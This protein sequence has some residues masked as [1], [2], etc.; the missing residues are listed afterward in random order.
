MLA[1]L[2]VV[3]ILQYLQILNNYVVYPM[4]IQCCMP[5]ILQLK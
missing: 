4:L 3:I 5:V 1:R 2:I